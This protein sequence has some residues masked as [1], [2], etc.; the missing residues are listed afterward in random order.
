[1]TYILATKAIK[2]AYFNLSSDFKELHTLSLKLL[3]RHGNYQQ[4]QNVS[5]TSLLFL[6]TRTLPA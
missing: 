5:T 2:F 4:K 3:L 1:M 6:K